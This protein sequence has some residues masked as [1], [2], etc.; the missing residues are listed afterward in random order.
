MC[1]IIGYIGSDNAYNVLIKDLELLEYR[2]YDSVG[3]AFSSGEVY[4]CAGR[5]A[6]LRESL[7]NQ[8]LVARC[9]I[10]H[11]RWATHGEVSDINAHPHQHGKVTLVHNGIIENYK[12]LIKEF[13]MEDQLLSTT[14]TEVVAVLLD[15]YYNGNPYEAIKKA[16]GRLKGTFAL[17]IMFADRPN[18]IYATR[19]VSPIVYCKTKE[20]VLLASD[21]MPIGQY[22]SEYYVEPEDCILKMDEK[23]FVL[24]DLNDN[25]VEPKLNIIDW[26]VTE[27]SKQGFSSY[28]EKEIA[29]QPKAIRDTVASYLCDGLPVFKVGEEIKRFDKLYIVACGTSRHIGLV[30]K[31]VFEKMVGIPV[32]VELA[33]E[34][35]Y[36][37][38]LI[39]EN[40]L[41]IGI[42]QSGETIDTL[43]SIKY[44]KRLGAY[45]ISLL[46]VK[47]SS[48]SRVSDFTMYA[49]AG[50][51]IAVAS[52]KAFTSQMSLLNVFMVFM[53][54]KRN[55]ITAVEAK[56]FLANFEETIAAC[57]KVIDEKEKLHLLSKI[58]IDQSDLFMIGRGL[59]Y[60]TLMEGSLKLKE[61]SYIHSEV[62]ASGELKHGPISLIDNDG[63]VITCVTQDRLLP[64]ALSSIKEVEA[65]GARVLAFV[66][67]DLCKDFVNEDVYVLPKLK[68]EFMVYPASVAYQLLA[69]YVAHD[70]GHDVDKPKNLAKVVTVE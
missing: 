24:T 21:L 36:E 7:K 64:K 10:G 40:S 62:Y 41:V 42:S 34:F 17:V 46:N 53:A 65:R 54:L 25:V 66:K 67:E 30:I 26:D 47:G 59:D 23:G 14:D 45:V 11:T 52:T 37:D 56:D 31:P 12:E 49:E 2:G 43:E 35:L 19:R 69:Y 13:E 61:I 44:A 57:Q 15:H 70:K 55:R 48:M 58:V 22:N 3:I 68:E 1:G 27:L 50:P 38:H 28:M 63:V 20:G 29:D 39:D 9:G 32:F 5:V 33:S 16:I 6:K 4:K 60:T 18:E 8:N 51:E